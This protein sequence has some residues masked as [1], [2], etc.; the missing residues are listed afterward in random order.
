MASPRRAENSKVCC[1]PASGTASSRS[2]NPAAVVP[3]CGAAVAVPSCAAVMPACVTA[4][5]YRRKG[6][7]SAKNPITSCSPAAPAC[8]WSA[9]SVRRAAMRRS[10]ASTFSES[11]S[12]IARVRSG[13]VRD[14]RVMSLQQPAA[15]AAAMLRSGLATSSLISAVDTT[16]GMWEIIAAALSC[17]SSSTTMTRL[18]TSLVIIAATS[19][20]RR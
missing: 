5:L 3:A 12:T 2:G 6:S 8:S 18:P 10:S 14:T 13:S 20:K 4:A 16:C 15:S 9:I 19:R 1:Q 7:P 17:V 11:S